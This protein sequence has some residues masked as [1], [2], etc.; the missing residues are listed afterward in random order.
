LNEA[1]LRA[2]RHAFEN[3]EVDKTYLAIVRGHPPNSGSIDHPLRKMLDRGP[4][5]K[6]DI[7]QE[8]L[9][10]YQT[11][12]AVELPIPTE[13]YPTTRYACVKLTPNTG[14]RHQLRRH[15]AHINCPIVGDTKHGDTRCNHAFSK[16]CGFIRLFL[17]A[18]RLSLL[19]PFTQEKIEIEAPVSSDFKQALAATGLTAD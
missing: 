5:R 13:R 14:R 17:H 12:S 7:A 4:K 9:T 1:A 18:R 6:S 19:H 15:L 2:A 16:R 3:N 8:A 11:L 10:R